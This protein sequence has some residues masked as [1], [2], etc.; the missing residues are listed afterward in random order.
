MPIVNTQP[1]VLNSSKSL[2]IDYSPHR[3]RSAGAP[4]NIDR[5]IA[6]ESGAEL[7]EAGASKT[8]EAQIISTTEIV[9]S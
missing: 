2:R 4:K 6:A 3:V 1:A 9:G 7:E 8:L 5:V